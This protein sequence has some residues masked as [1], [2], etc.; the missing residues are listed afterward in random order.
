M[1]K[2]FRRAVLENLHLELK[3]AR[4]ER[5]LSQTDV[6]LQTDISLAELNRM[7]AGAMIS[8]KK[9]K[10]LIHFYGKEI[11]FILKDRTR[12]PLCKTTRQ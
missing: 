8:F 9:Y 1:I 7:E 4:L 2:N 6:A 5:G 10:Q 12:E 3:Q 11:H